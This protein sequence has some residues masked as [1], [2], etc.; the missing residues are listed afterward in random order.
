[1]SLFLSCRCQ[2]CLKGQTCFY[3]NWS[4]RFFF[5]KGGAATVFSKFRFLE[6]AI[7]E[8]MR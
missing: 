2:V 6:P 7:K 1:M 8:S 3:S 5:D 4:I